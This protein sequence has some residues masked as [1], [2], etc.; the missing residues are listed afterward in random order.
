MF[1]HGAVGA[2]VVY[3]RLAIVNCTADDKTKPKALGI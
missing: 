3:S 1:H 2:V